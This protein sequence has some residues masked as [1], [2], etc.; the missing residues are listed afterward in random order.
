MATLPQLTLDFNRQIKMN[1]S[2]L[3]IF[4]KNSFDIRPASEKRKCL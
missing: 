1:N 3:N 2:G 4:I